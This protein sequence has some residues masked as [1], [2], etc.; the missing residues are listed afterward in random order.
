MFSNEDE[1]MD[2]LDDDEISKIQRQSLEK[3]A[4][5][6]KEYIRLKTLYTYFESMQSFSK[7]KFLYFEE[8]HKHLDAMLNA[9][10]EKEEYERCANIRDWIIRAK[11]IKN[12][13]ETKH[14]DENKPRRKKTQITF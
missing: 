8:N 2:W 10:I 7:D 12:K 9:F 1:F 14:P 6:E 4:K 5:E 3:Q 13:L 11:E